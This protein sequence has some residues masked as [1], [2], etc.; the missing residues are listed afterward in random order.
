MTLSN[1]LITGE[2]NIDEKNGGEMF[3]KCSTDQSFIQTEMTTYGIGT[4]VL[5]N[6]FQILKVIFFSVLVCSGKNKSRSYLNGDLQDIKEQ[7]L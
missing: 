3:T 7:Y 4:L 2:S 1:V 5:I 6:V